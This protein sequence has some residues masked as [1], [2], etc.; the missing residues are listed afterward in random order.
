MGAGRR[1]AFRPHEITLPEPAQP[2]PTTPTLTHG[3]LAAFAASAG[4][5]VLHDPAGR[6]EQV[7]PAFCRLVGRTE[8]TLVGGSLFAVVHPDDRESVWEVLRRLTDGVAEVEPAEVRYVHGSGREVWAL[9]NVA[10]TRDPD[11]RPAHFACHAIDITTRKAAEQRLLDREA[12][13]R[14]VLDAAGAGAWELDYA[15][16]RADWSVTF[17]TLIGRRPDELTASHAGWRSLLPPDDLAR[18]EAELAD[19]FARQATDYRSEYRIT[20]PARGECWLLDVGRINYTDGRPA[21]AAGVALDIT[22]RRR[23][24]RAVRDQAERLRAVFD[25]AADAIVA[26]GRDGTVEGMNRAAERMF[27]YSP[28]ELTGQNVRV[29]MPAPHRDAHDGYLA[30]YLQTGERRIIGVGRELVGRRKDGSLFPIELAVGES[31]T[32]SAHWFTGIIRDITERKRSEEQLRRHAEL[33]DKIAEAVVVWDADDRVTFWNRGAERLYGWSAAETVGRPV[34]DVFGPHDRDAWDRAR[35][36]AREYGEWDGEMRQVARDGRPLVIESHWTLLR[37]DQGVPAGK[38]V[39]QIDISEKKS[40]ESRFLR[41]QRLES[42]GTLVG[43]IAHDLNN[44]LTPVLM[45]VKLLRANKPGID[46]QALLDAA[47]T[48]VERGAALIRQLLAFAGGLDG[49]R[50]RVRLDQVAEEVCG[51]LE[52]SLPKTVA[53]RPAITPAWP[54]IGDSTQ[55]SQVLM[56]LC[57]NARDAMPGGGTLTVAVENMVLTAVT[58][59]MYPDGRPGAYAVLTVTDTGTGIAPAVLEKMFDPFFT[60]KPF[61]QGTGL[62]LSTVRGIVKS[63]GGFVNVYSEVGVGTKVMVYLPAVPD[64]AAVV[65]PPAVAIPSGR[66]ELILVVDDEPLILTTT[67]A[68]LTG[69]GYQVLTAAGGEAGIELYR[70]HRHRVAVVLLDMMMPGTDGPA[71]LSALRGLDPGVKVLAASGLRPAGRVAEAVAAGSVGF[72]QKPYSDETL[73]AALAELLRPPGRG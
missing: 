62:G 31:K 29:L 39:I 41:A 18:V 21:R 16:G 47:Q 64:A 5:L 57:V 36:H 25:T 65:T 51:M 32:E 19:L 4:G 23:A 70:Q 14:L 28:G 38:I 20:H 11:G 15:T 52:H 46:R 34:G 27:G 33:L 58:A 40:L 9:V 61:G 68:A 50:D 24:E 69:S 30:R 2:D 59:A 37:D 12:R 13:L 53:I 54:L 43:G 1:P 66:G 67:A 6:I 3:C 35:A 48:S 49:E 17:Y 7:N 63:H 55:L 45:A 71:V 8:A 26:I 44:M 56:N 42:V 22:E 10:V 73:A 72:L 60:T